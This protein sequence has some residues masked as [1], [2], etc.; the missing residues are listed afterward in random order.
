VGCVG[1]QWAALSREERLRCH[2]DMRIAVAGGT[3]TLGRHVAEELGARGHDVRVLSRNAPVYR[4]DLTTGAGL[5]AAL[6]GCDVV[7]DAANNSS[8]RAAL[9]L[10][11]GSRRLLAAGRAAGVRHHV[12]VSIVGCERI[13]LGYYRA[14]ADQERVVEQGPVPWSLVRATQFHELIAAALDALGRWR[15]LPVPRARLQ[16]IASVEVAR[17]VADVAEGAPLGR[18]IEVAGPEITGARELA[19][20]WMSITG[21]SALLVPLPVPGRLGRALRSGELA[22]E[23]PDVRGT[24]DFASW[25][26]AARS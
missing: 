3:G 13:P 19:R 18:R 17:V 5:G 15:V 21:R 20:T 24:V 8:R 2:E 10:V 7:V 14:K 16:T 6:D 25:L 12:C 1:T 26:K 4:V 22:A 23:R 11:D 9:T